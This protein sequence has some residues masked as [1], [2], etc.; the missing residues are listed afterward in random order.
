MCDG[1]FQSSQSFYLHI[2]VCVFVFCLF[3]LNRIVLTVA[4]K[5]HSMVHLRSARVKNDG[6]FN[7]KP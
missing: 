5:E 2:T 4:V 7:I 3:F 6:T 1:T